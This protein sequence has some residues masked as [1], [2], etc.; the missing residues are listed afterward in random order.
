MND[1]SFG[2]SDGF[3]LIEVFIVMVVTMTL[4]AVAIPRTST[5]F[6]DLRLSGDARALSN[7]I[8]L[9][10]MRAAADFTRA[11]LRANIAARTYQIERLQKTVPPSWVGED[12]AISLS[13][14]VNLS[15]GSLTTAPPNTQPAVAMAPPC[16]DGEG[17]AIANTACVVFN[18]RGIP[19]DNA[20]N[21]TGN[22]ALYVTDGTAVYGVTVGA[23]G[24][25]RLW[26]SGPN[27][28][29]WI[30]Q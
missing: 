26:K 21:P 14:Q 9:A 17:A 10:K 2:S 16:L 27:A 8:A 20:G 19:I 29:I 15:P 30:K 23:T 18:S 3:S 28:A 7:S 5:L 12:D 11:R 4:A 25:I 24:L 1:R 13:Y 22:D 6:G